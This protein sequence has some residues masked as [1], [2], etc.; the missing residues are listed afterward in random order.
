MTVIRNSPRTSPGSGFVFYG[1]MLFAIP[2]LVFL[3]KKKKIPIWDYLDVVAIFAPVLHLFGRLGCFMAGCCHGKVCDPAYGIVFTDP[4]SS[5]DP[6]NVPLYPTQLYSVALL[7]SI[8]VLLYLIRNK[9]QFSGQL[10][11]L[12]IIIYSIGRGIIEIFRG[13]EARGYV[14]ENVLSHSQTI[15]LGIILIASIVWVKRLRATKH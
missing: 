12:Y 10:F 13:D 11:L 1:S 6:L 15:A 2:T 7:L 8:A 5:A 9:K 3:L 4:E 14:I